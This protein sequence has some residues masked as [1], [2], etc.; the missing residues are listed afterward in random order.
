MMADIRNSGFALMKTA[1]MTESIDDP[2]LTTRI[3]PR[4]RMK[5]IGHCP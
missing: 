4:W 2:G 5:V 3:R 1:W